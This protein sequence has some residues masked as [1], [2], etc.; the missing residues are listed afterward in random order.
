MSLLYR[1]DAYSYARQTY[2]TVS[3]TRSPV[4]VPQNPTVST[5]RHVK[6]TTK[7]PMKAS[8]A[9]PPVPVLKDVS[10]ACEKT[11]ASV[12]ALYARL[13]SVKRPGQNLR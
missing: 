12:A 7:A 13:Q 10:A 6:P 5:N 9:T 2:A 8:V 11:D 4:A 3:P 1:E